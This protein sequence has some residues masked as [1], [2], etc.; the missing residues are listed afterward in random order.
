MVNF[1]RKN[2][3]KLYAYYPLTIIFFI[4]IGV[5]LLSAIP[6]VRTNWALATTVKPE[7]FTELY[8]ENHLT[9]PSV[10]KPNQPY[11][12]EFT[13]HNVENKDMTYPY[14]V[15]LQAG[16]VKLPINRNTVTIKNNQYKTIHESFSVN[17]PVT[18]CEIVV[19]LLNKNQQI[20]FWI[21]SIT[22]SVTKVTPTTQV[23]KPTIQETPTPEPILYLPVPTLPIASSSGTASASAT[24]QYGGWYWNPDANKDM[25]WLG[26]N[27]NGQDIWSDSLP[28]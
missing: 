12:F 22:P 13:I 3:K 6:S 27:S 17:A 25:V 19:N 18:K 5:F 20:D 8:F 9:L 7:T 23:K 24:K 15:Y 14:A 26:E 2:L 10:I 11:Y 4:I 28:Q 21:E 16:S 1:L